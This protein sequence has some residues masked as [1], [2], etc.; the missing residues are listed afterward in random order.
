VELEDFQAVVDAEP[1][2]DVREATD[3]ASGKEAYSRRG[4]EGDKTRGWGDAWGSV[5]GELEV[6]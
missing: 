3:A 6:R 5:S 2:V 1:F 4:P